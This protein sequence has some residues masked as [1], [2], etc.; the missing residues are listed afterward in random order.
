MRGR[1]ASPSSARS[2]RRV[3]A[4]SST[5]TRGGRRPRGAGSTGRSIC[6]ARTASPPTAS[7]STRT[8]STSSVTRSS[9]SCRR[10]T[11]S[12][13]PRTRGEVRLA[14]ARR[15]R[16]HPVGGRRP[17]RARRRR[18]RRRGRRD[19]VLV[20]ANQTVVGE[21]LLDAIR[22]RARPLAG[23]LPHRL[24]RRATSA[25]PAIPSA[26]QRLRQAVGMLRA[27]GIDVHGQIGHPD[28]YTAA[29]QAIYDER[30]R[31]AHRLDVPRHEVGL[32][33]W[34]SRRAAREGHEAARSR[35][36]S[37][38]RSRRRSPRS[39]SPRRRAHEHDTASIRPPRTSRRASTR[40]CSGC[41]SSSA[42]RSCSSGRSSPRT[43]SSA[44]STAIRGR[45]RATPA[46]V[47]RGRQHRHP[48]HLELH[49]ALGAAVDQARQPCG[50]EG[51]ARADAAHGHD[52]PADADRGVRARRLRPRETTPSRRSS[53]A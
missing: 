38:S 28:P 27:E 6:C 19:N 40:A 30:T 11:P 36:S 51:G 4:T 32:A 21:P 33:A 41:C 5:R 10:P 31:R 7:S 26:E 15:R 48:R 50:T 12:S 29:M 46:E 39:G 44:S 52:V 14:A 37:R 24:A 16:A 22:E 17:R 2:R 13:S 9:S 1:S 49:D 8:P 42:R 18:S 25:S 20:I 53:T 34:R 47:R 43:S 45:P 35:T 3:T 23:E